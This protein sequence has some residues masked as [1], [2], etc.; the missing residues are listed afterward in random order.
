MNKL[1]RH[2]SAKKFQVDDEYS[3][4]VAR[5]GIVNITNSLVEVKPEPI[6]VVYEDLP[7]E[8]FSIDITNG[9]TA[10]AREEEEKP[11]VD[12]VD[13]MAV[14]GMEF[15]CVSFLQ[16]KLISKACCQIMLMFHLNFLGG[17]QIFHQ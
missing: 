4:N 8:I 15:E 13:E 12:V 7:T 1:N 16:A 5:K 14:D 9:G 10:H 3:K 6:A 17:L 11:N 2:F